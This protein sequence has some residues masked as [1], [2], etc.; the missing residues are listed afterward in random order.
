MHQQN[1][2]RVMQTRF[3]LTAA[4]AAAALSFTGCVTS[5]P[6]TRIAQN[7]AL[8]DSLALDVR[9]KIAAG[10]VDLGFTPDMV[11]LA[12]GKPSRRVERIATNETN[13]IWYYTRSRPRV[14]FG[15]GLGMG[16][17]GRHGGW[18]SG[19]GVSTGTGGYEGDEMMRVEFSEGRVSAVDVRR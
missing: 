3:L 17:F 15:V 14:S 19:I 16:G 5:N 2:N 11:Y 13:E 10:R 6:D 1:K 18:G 12:L 4:L 9:E 7:R 8:Y